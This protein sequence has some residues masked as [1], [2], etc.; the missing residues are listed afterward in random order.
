MF[1]V[2]CHI[3][4]LT[5]CYINLQPLNPIINKKKEMY[6]SKPRAREQQE[7]TFAKARVFS[8]FPAPSAPTRH[9]FCAPLRRTGATHHFIIIRSALLL[10]ASLPPR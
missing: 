1:K 4:C 10:L 8:L 3:S 5:Q 7:Y 2:Y 9:S 6:L